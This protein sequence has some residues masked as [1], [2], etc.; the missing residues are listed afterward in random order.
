MVTLLKFAVQNSDAQLI[1]LSPQDVTVIHEAKA[2]VQRGMGFPD[3][4]N[5]LNI[6]HMRHQRHG[7]D[8]S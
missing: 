7:A 8:R 3:P 4:D 6:V 1:L 5:F 2:Q